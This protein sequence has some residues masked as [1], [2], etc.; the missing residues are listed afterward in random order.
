MK[1]LTILLGV[2]VVASGLVVAYALWG[3]L[4]EVEPLR[5]ELDAAE[6][7]AAWSF[8]VGRDADY[9]VEFHVDTTYSKDVDAAAA[10]IEWKLLER[11]TIVGDGRTPIDRHPTVQGGG[12]QGYTLDTAHLVRG[13]D[14]ELQVKTEAA[15]RLASHNGEMRVALHPTDLEYL[16]GL[17]IRG[18][19]A[20]GLL[21]TAFVSC[22]GVMVYRKLAK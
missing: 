3:P 21:G 12:Y 14:Y 10:S 15:Q 13:V 4:Y 19:A 5:V 17:G 8:Q 1:Y 16:V 9:L 11:D 22:I 18:L 6:Q 20:L 2:G 7:E